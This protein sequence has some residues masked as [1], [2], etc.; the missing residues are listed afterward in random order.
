MVRSVSAEEREYSTK[1]KHP[2]RNGGRQE[3]TEPLIEKVY[4]TSNLHNLVLAQEDEGALQNRLAGDALQ[5][6]SVVANLLL[7]DLHEQ[8]E[9]GFIGRSVSLVIHDDQ[10]LRR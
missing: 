1:A 7:V 5:C 3:Q 2:A 10:S 8:V 4:S 6:V 9:R